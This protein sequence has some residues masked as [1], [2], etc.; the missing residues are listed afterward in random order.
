MSDL[1]AKHRKQSNKTLSDPEVDSDA[2]TAH[3]DRTSGPESAATVH[4][5]PLE[6]ASHLSNVDPDAATRIS[7]RLRPGTRSTLHMD[8]RLTPTTDRQSTQEI[9]LSRL[10]ALPGYRYQSMLGRGGMGVV[11][12]AHD[13]RLDRDVAIKLPLPQFLDDHQFR[14]RFLREA[15]SVAALRHPNICPIYDFGEHGEQL[16]LVLPHIEGQTLD[17]WLDEAQPDARHKADILAQIADGV[18]AAHAADIVHRDLKPSNIQIDAK[19]QSPVLMDFGLAKQAVDDGASLLTQDGQV[20]G[21]PAYMAPEQARG[22]HDV[23]PAADIYSL[24]AIL[25]EMLTDQRPYRG[26]M[27]E[28][29]LKLEDGPPPRPKKINQSIHSDLET[30]CLKAMERSPQD[31]YS[32]AAELAADLRRFAAGEAIQAKRS[33]AGKRL[34]HLIKRHKLAV[35]SSSLGILIVLSGL[36]WVWSLAEKNSQV[37]VLTTAINSL[38]QEAL[39]VDARRSRALDELQQL[40]ALDPSAAVPLRRQLQQSLL[41]CFHNTLS[42][43]RLRENDVQLLHG[44]IS[45][46]ALLGLDQRQQLE[47]EITNRRDSWDPLATFHGDHPAWRSVAGGWQ[48]VQELTQADLTASAIICSGLFDI[49]VVWQRWSESNEIGFA[50]LADTEPLYTLKLFSD[51]LRSAHRETGITLHLLRGQDA[52]AEFQVNT[53]TLDT[54]KSLTMSMRNNQGQIDIHVNGQ[55]FHFRDIFP[56]S[57]AGADIHLLQTSAVVLTSLSLKTYSAG[58]NPS[59]LQ[60]GDALAAENRW[61]EAQAAYQEQARISKD[62][63]LQAEATYKQAVC[64]LQQQRIQAGE[65]ILT[66]LLHAGDQQWSPIAGCQLWASLLQRDALEEA[67]VVAHL[68]SL[69]YDRASLTARLPFDLRRRIIRHYARSA[70]GT[71]LLKY[72]PQRVERIE[73]LARVY[74]LLETSD[75]QRGH[76]AQLHIRAL[77]WDGRLQEALSIGKAF[78]RTTTRDNQRWIGHVA[79]ECSWILR[80]LDRPKEALHLL[81][82][83]LAKDGQGHIAPG[84]ASAE[85][86]RCLDALGRHDEAV[87]YLQTCNRDA[88]LGT[89]YKAWAS[90]W[91]LLAYWQGDPQQQQALYNRARFSN[92]QQLRGTTVDANSGF[93]TYYRLYCAGVSDHKEEASQ[94]L[95]HILASYVNNLRNSGEPNAIFNMLHVKP[96]IIHT[97]WQTR[98]GQAVA[99]HFMLRS[100]GVKTLTAELMAL[101]TGQM[102]NHK[103]YNGKASELA[104]DVIWSTACDAF[105][106]YTDGKLDTKTLFGLAMAYKGISSA[107]GWGL[108][109]KGLP[110]HLLGRTA[111]FFSIRFANKDQHD[112]AEQLRN[113]AAAHAE[114][115][116]KLQELLRHE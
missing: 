48:P 34:L 92:W 95:S 75:T 99:R 2:E 29:L 52:I 71:G 108:A 35:A 81:N 1:P 69:E 4:T 98:H 5:Q 49:Q 83:Y 58:A 36:I 20:V 74:D 102:T 112:V 70:M 113:L 67:E 97:M 46:L 21:T 38:N 109:E 116:P 56:V 51:Q 15:R 68:L 44:M 57:A 7:E 90:V 96:S 26:G 22:S 23:G 9:E 6:D 65:D 41:D 100:T 110:P 11:I 19:N 3:D 106:A 24:G 86:A 76:A 25:Y 101:M 27:R 66:E 82:H 33:S 79:D 63:K 85:Y 42:R 105:F 40:E 115:Q 8:S 72:D 114:G 62:S 47:A 31:R 53:D 60:Q 10:A 45:D 88:L 55:H 111:Y 28:V 89:D 91:C 43:P 37:M 54:Q 30:I 94:V 17:D 87:A 18:A 39:L 73:S 13:T 104:Q 84:P 12:K 93:G 78:L 14:E 77:H 107:M 103:L 64:L 32:S 59:P 61:N 50:C 80:Q 16:Y